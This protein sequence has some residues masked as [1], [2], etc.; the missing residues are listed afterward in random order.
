MAAD[1]DEHTGTNNVMDRLIVPILLP[2]VALIVT[3]ALIV[4]IG[5]LLYAV[6]PHDYVTLAGEKVYYSVPVALGLALIFL[7]GFAFLASR[8]PDENNDDSE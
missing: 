5:L 7:I 3:I 6:V 1:H 4:A 2:V 8:A